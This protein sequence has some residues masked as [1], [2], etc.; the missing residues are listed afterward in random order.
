MPKIRSINEIAGKWT[1][2]TP[3]RHTQYK[4]GVE[5]PKESWM[6]QTLAA[7]DSYVEGVQAS[8][9]AGRFPRGVTDAG[10]EKWK[11][12]TLVVGVPRWPT[13][14]RAAG[15]DYSKGFSPY[16]DVIEATTLPGRYAKG[17]PR[18]YDRVVA[19]GSALHAAKIA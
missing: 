16:R 17:D 15:P 4:A 10:D 11:R 3:G 5:R 7:A 8:I 2:V 13:G 12:K 18:N 19:M 14:V 9:A 1:E 6:A